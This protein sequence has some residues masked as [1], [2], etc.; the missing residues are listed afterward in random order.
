M[1]QRDKLTKQ[2]AMYCFMLD[3][4]ALYLDTHPNNRK[5]LAAFDAYRKM[6]LAAK[7]EYEAAY[8]PVTVMAQP[9]DSETWLWSTTPW[10]WENEVNK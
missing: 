7:A 2:M 4:I 1:T 8:G 10:P 5:A 3:D 9:E 6:Y